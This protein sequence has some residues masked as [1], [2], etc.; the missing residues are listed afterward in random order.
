[1]FG[2][3]IVRVC[4]FPQFLQSKLISSGTGRFYIELPPRDRAKPSGVVGPVD[5]PPCRR[6]R[7]YRPVRSLH[8][9]GARQIVP[10]RVHAPQRA[11]PVRGTGPAH[12]RTPMPITEAPS[13]AAAKRPL[14][15]L[16]SLACHSMSFVH[17]GT[18]ET[19]ELLQQDANLAASSA[20]SCNYFV[21]LCSE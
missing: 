5:L 14:F 7:V 3:E 17:H 19:G 9:A 1:M 16:E 4:T 8:M 2:L 6:Q 21:I 20:T 12:A 18:L 11:I 13:F 10:L 15:T